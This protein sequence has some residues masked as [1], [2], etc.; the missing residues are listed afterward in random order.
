VAT[1]QN[2]E[3]KIEVVLDIF[4]GRPNPTWQLSEN[5]VDELKRKLGT[6][7][8]AERKAPPGLGYRGVRVVNV[9]NI[10]NI[11]D[12]IMAYDGV[13]GITEK[14]TTKYY[15]DSNKIEEWLLDRAREQGYGEVIERFR[16]YSRK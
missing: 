9:G 8:P 10:A 6:F 7:P 3:E 13:L 12:R 5:Q 11:P 2:G 16:Q 4:S 14:G 15:E 1:A